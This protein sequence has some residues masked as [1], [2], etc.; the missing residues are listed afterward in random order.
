MLR[1]I[2]V[3]RTDELERAVSAEITKLELVESRT[4]G[5][6]GPQVPR[7]ASLLLGVLCGDDPASRGL[8]R[9]L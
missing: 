7:L 2:G 3:A 5:A 6:G 1:E 4:A 9:S 8:A